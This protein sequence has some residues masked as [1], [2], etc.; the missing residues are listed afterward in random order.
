MIY[1]L[2]FESLIYSLSNKFYDIKRMMSKNRKRH[3]LEINLE[4]KFD[5]IRYKREFLV[6]KE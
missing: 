3:Y 5:F 6:Y 4:R 1:W 2:M